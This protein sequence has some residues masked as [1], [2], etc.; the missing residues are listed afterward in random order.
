MII[1]NI[2]D[3]QQAYD[4]IKT[5]VHRTP[6][7]TSS[8]INKMLGAEFYFKCENFQKIGAFKFRGS[9]NAIMQLPKEKLQNGVTTHSSGNFAQALALSAKMNNVP[10]YIVMP[11]NAPIVKQN[12]VKGYGAEVILCTPTLEARETTAASVIKRTGATFIHP[13]D[14]FDIVCGQGTATIE[15]LQDYTNLDI[16]IAPVGGGGLIS[17]TAIAAKGINPNIIV[18]AGEPKGADDAYRSF[19]SGKFVPSV[20]PN[21]I[22]DGLLTSLGKINYEIIKQHVDDIITV[23]EEDIIDA[24]RLIYER[25]KIIVEPSSAVPLAA[26]IESKANIKGKRIGIIISGGNVEL[27]K[28]PF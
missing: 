7:L 24:M 6:V 28:L 18:W 22:G 8:L 23:S 16:V 25:V 9:T 5:K 27:S 17:G 19:K 13:Y 1:P 3:I 2:D 15:L 26:L 14:D 4:R 10:A 21:T 12:A 11:Q 20:N